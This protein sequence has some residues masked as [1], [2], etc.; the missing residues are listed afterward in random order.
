M[1]VNSQHIKLETTI[2]TLAVDTRNPDFEEELNRQWSVEQ[3]CLSEGLLGSVARRTSGG[4]KLALWGRRR[5]Y[6]WRS[7]RFVTNVETGKNVYL[8]CP[9]TWQ[10]GHP[11]S[12]HS[13]HFRTSHHYLLQPVDKL[14]YYNSISLQLGLN[15]Y[16]VVN[17]YFKRHH[18]LRKSYEIR[19]LGAS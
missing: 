1:R 9:D 3:G 13:S 10:S 5:H 11:P 12:H 18:K 7:G 2:K 8:L 4:T 15:I 6:F 16:S 17:L 19:V 14:Y